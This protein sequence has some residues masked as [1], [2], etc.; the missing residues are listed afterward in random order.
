MDI[1][2]NLF[3]IPIEENYDKCYH[4]QLSLNFG[5]NEVHMSQV[6]A[7]WRAVYITSSEKQFFGGSFQTLV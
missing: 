5:W 2:E 3:S 1:N 6:K 7:T 4:N